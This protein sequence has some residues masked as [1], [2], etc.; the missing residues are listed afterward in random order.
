[1]LVK[2]F[3]QLSRSRNKKR[4]NSVSFTSVK[5]LTCI[6][7]DNPEFSSLC[8][9]IRIKIADSKFQ[10]CIFHWGNSVRANW[11]CVM[12]AL[13][14]NKIYFTILG[15]FPFPQIKSPY[16]KLLKTFTF[17]FCLVTLSFNF[18][19]AG[20]YIYKNFTSLSQFPDVMKAFVSLPGTKRYNK[21]ILL[22]Q[23]FTRYKNW[24]Y[25][26]LFE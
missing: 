12:E 23:A 18:T 26:R 1:M 22:K 20:A 24:F 3:R 11:T 10:V 19:A 16:N 17:C 21:Y 8:I 2:I 6:F 15:I 7:F 9:S 25:I 14:Y 13:K 5:L 4:P